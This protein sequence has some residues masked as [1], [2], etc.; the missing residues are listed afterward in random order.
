MIANSS[1]A[2]PGLISSPAG[3]SNVAVT[4]PISATT[5]KKPM[6]ATITAG[7]TQ[8]WLATPSTSKTMHSKTLRKTAP[9]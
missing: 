6:Q 8:F 9:R 4:A 3:G 7:T 1:G 2:S 5:P